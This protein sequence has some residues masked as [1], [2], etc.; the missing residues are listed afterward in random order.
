MQENSTYNVDSNNYWA[1][2]FDTEDH[3][4]EEDKQPTMP[5]I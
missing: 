4:D 1:P 2:L 5:T 3:E